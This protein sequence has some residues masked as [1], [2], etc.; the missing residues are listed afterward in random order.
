V[1]LSLSHPKLLTEICSIIL[2]QKKIN[3]KKI[4]LFASLVYLFIA[5]C[6]A[7]QPQ[8]TANPQATLVAK[9]NILEGRIFHIESFM[10]DGTKVGEED[11]IFKN[12]TLEGSECNKFGYDKPSATVLGDR[13]Q[14]TMTSTKEGTLAWDGRVIGNQ[15]EGTAL[16]TKVGQPTMAMTF[17]GAEKK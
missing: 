2:N 1:I 7:Q 11:V 16:W 8:N 13:F 17:K 4:Q 9:T 3:M 14:A 12:S 5:A 15:I 6:T 10:P